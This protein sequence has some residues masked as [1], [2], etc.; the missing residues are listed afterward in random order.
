[1]QCGTRRC[2]ASVE[3]YVDGVRVTRSGLICDNILV[4]SFEPTPW[5][6]KAHLIGPL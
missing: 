6:D 1:M 5:A 2:E 3:M 4:H